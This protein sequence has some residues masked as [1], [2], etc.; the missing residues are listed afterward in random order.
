MTSKC[1]DIHLKILNEHP[2]VKKGDKPKELI[3]KYHVFTVIMYRLNIRKFNKSLKYLCTRGNSKERKNAQKLKSKAGGVTDD[4]L[5]TISMILRRLLPRGFHVI[6]CKNN[7][8]NNPNGYKDIKFFR[9]IPK[10]T[11]LIASDEDEESNSSKH[12]QSF[13]YKNY[14]MND[15]THFY[16]TIKSNGENCKLG[17]LTAKYTDNEDIIYAISG[18][19]NTC[20]I[21]PIQEKSTKYI[22]IM[23]DQSKRIPSIWIAK[24]YSEFL[25]DLKENNSEIYQEYIKI[26]YI[27]NDYIIMGEINEPWSE[28]ILPINELFIDTYAILNNNSKDGLPIDSNIAFKYF[29][30]FNM[31]PKKPNLFKY[32]LKMTIKDL[33]NVKSTIK[34]VKYNKHDIKDLNKCIDSIRDDAKYEGS[35]L[36]ICNKL[37][38]VIGLCKVK[39]SEYVV[40]RRIRERMKNALWYPIR[41]GKIKEFKSY[42]I[43][44][45]KTMWSLDERRQFGLTSMHN[46]MNKLTFLPNHNKFKIAWIKYAKGFV[47]WWID[48]RLKTLESNDNLHNNLDYVMQEIDERYASLLQEYDLFL[49][50]K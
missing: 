24:I 48:T 21:W 6:Y 25:M 31:E 49:S 44:K 29:K 14:K 15:A 7:I 42:K 12:N 4:G 10:F 34:H 39:S 47:N 43:N 17:L 16:E 3:F 13:F 1:K 36:Y 20:D 30:E 50:N 41:G 45:T 8:E 35:V 5:Y 11:G 38:N 46:G 37:D 23:I 28:H 18:S 32:D 40:R 2:F 9:G 22:P 27:D 19:K 33:M 26:M